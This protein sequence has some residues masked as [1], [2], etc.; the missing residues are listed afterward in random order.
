MPKL[1]HR[2][3]IMVDIDG[4]LADFEA[5]FCEDFGYDNRDEYNFY[6]R[7]PFLDPGLITEYVSDPENYK[8]LLPI[9]GGA[10]FCQEAK[11]RGYY[12]LLVT[13]RDTKLRE[14]TKAWLSQYNIQYNELGFSKNKEEFIRDFEKINAN[15]KVTMVVDDSVS[16]FAGMVGRTCFVWEQRWNQGYYPRISYDYVNF[17]L[18]GKS[19][20]EDRWH[21]I[22]S[23]DENKF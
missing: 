14:A 1:I 10:L 11:S 2:D 22:W 23:K 5:K 12:V 15:L 8:D 6:K 20:K 21:W 7:Y 16:S 19:S 4:V 17:R 13:S 18:V 9:F 3:A